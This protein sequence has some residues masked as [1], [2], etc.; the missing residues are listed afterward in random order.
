M[1]RD[2]EG[3]ARE[4]KLD[5]GIAHR[6]IQSLEKWQKEQ[7]P[8]FSPWFQFTALSTNDFAS[9]AKELC[10]RGFVGSSEGTPDAGKSVNALVAQV[11]A[12]NSPGS[13]KEV[14]ERYGKLFADVEAHR[15]Q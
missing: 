12:S 8:I 15:A 3:L 9:K 13:M 5:P 10:A 11:F 2:S 1:C 6:W 4:G 7:H 14:A